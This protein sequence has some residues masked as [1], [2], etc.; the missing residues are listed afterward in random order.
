MGAANSRDENRTVVQSVPQDPPARPG[1]K[2]TGSGLLDRATRTFSFGGQKKHPLPP[3]PSHEPVPD[4]P[5]VLSLGRDT[6]SQTPRPMGDHNASASSNG[7]DLGGDF[8]SM[9]KTFDK[10]SSVATVTQLDSATPRSLTGNRY[11]AAGP[12]SPDQPTASEP[13][14]NSLHG[15]GQADD[16]AYSPTS[17]IDSHRQHLG[18]FKQSNRDGDNPPEDEDAKLLRDSFA[19]MKFL[20]S[21][22]DG[23]SSQP[24]RHRYGGNDGYS[25]LPSRTAIASD[26]S[27][28]QEE[29]MFE[30]SLSRVS[31]ISHRQVHRSN[32]FGPP[33]NKVMTPAQF[34]QY[35][36]DKERSSSKY[37]ASKPVAKEEDEEEDEINYE[38]DDDDQEKSKQQA[39]QRRK[40]EAHMAVYRQ[41][42]MKVTGEPASNPI[43]RVTRPGLPKTSS[44]PALAQMKAPSPDPGHGV[45]DEEE[46]EDVPLAILQA[47]GFPAKA[48][49]PSRLNNVGSS[50]NLRASAGTPTGGRPASVMGD[51]N[52][53]R[54]HSTLP[55]FA[56]SLP[57]DP[58]VGASIARPAVRE[59]LAFGDAKQTPLPP[60]APGGLVGVIA[61]EERSR[62]MR[63]GSPSM[64][65]NRLSGPPPNMN[66]G[67]PVDP[68]AGIPP[69]MMYNGGP[70]MQ[71]PMLSP[72]DQAQIQMTQQMQQF[73][74][75][76]MQFMQMMTAN[77][78]GGAPP[79]QSPYGGGFSG[80]PSTPNL[81]SRNSFMGDPMMAPPV[82]DPNSRTMSMVQPSSASFM[83]LGRPMSM[84]GSGGGNAPSIAPSERSNVG[85]P[86]RYRPVSRV[87]TS[88]VTGHS[89]SNT[90]SGALSCWGDEKLGSGLRQVTASREGSDVDDDEGWE[91]MKTKRDKKRSIWRSKKSSTQEL[92]IPA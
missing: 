3:P 41:Q 17:P 51:S 44:A 75:M 46:D 52:A 76:Q 12:I 87:S 9:F 48:R 86:G 42:M 84:R 40:Q 32:N 85:L 28:N 26:F 45:S 29:N 13:L 43:P 74:H 92:H 19:A 8:G 49:A 1:S 69:H 59:S 66:G 37:A 33:K 30:G 63:R 15:P 68:M 54:R 82:M 21:P 70:M 7:M 73:M 62:A 24:T 27:R 61:N 2:S 88:P 25:A 77:Q 39:K 57:Q 38:D 64:D 31:R 47:H 65:T 23:S 81:A 89:R 58:F 16:N 60:G 83:A 67:Y 6:P 10:R 11:P 22:Y 18:S 4:L 71:P 20:S 35:R 90:M 14:L 80:H 34:E 50:Q 36:Q 55:A 91:A 5:P 78:N 72:G 56:R 79:T 53:S